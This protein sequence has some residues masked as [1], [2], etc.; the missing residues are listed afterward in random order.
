MVRPYRVNLNIDVG[1]HTDGYN[2]GAPLVEVALSRGP[3]PVISG[4]E[5][6]GEDRHA[7][8]DLFW[9][10][11]FSFA[12]H[13]EVKISLRMRAIR[14]SAKAI[15]KAGSPT[16]ETQQRCRL[17]VVAA[18]RRQPRRSR[19]VGSLGSTLAGAPLAPL[20]GEVPEQSWRGGQG[21]Q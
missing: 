6:G 14:D 1:V 10:T 20:G 5:T 17:V 3:A 12:P 8:C 4:M 21:G 15:I 7:N 9:S 11:Q 2:A 18:R 16:Q 19:S 13:P